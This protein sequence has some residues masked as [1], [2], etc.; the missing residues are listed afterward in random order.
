MTERIKIIPLPWGDGE[1]MGVKLAGVVA[2]KP[3]SVHKDAH[4]HPSLFR[5]VQRRDLSAWLKT[6]VGNTDKMDRSARDKV[7]A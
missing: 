3:N 6:A 7:K 2:E 1:V 5:K 4:F